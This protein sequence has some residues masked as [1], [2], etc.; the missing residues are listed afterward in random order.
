MD[1]LPGQ[2]AGLARTGDENTLVL[3]DVESGG[4]GGEAAA[5]APGAR[6]A[7]AVGSGWAEDGPS[8]S[9]P[10]P[11]EIVADAKPVLATPCGVAREGSLL[12]P[13]EKDK[14]GTVKKKHKFKENTWDIFLSYR[15][16]A[17]QA[18]VSAAPTARRRFCVWVC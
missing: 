16:A 8:S 5:E 11:I 4:A 6:L 17:D 18:L 14:K 9:L 13:P 2:V 1:H 15:V 7:G 12:A 10:P 3:V